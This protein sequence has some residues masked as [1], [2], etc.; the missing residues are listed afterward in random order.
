[1][2]INLVKSENLTQ[3]SKKITVKSASAVKALAAQLKDSALKFYTLYE[4]K[5]TR[6][7]HFSS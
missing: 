2:L 6:L 3:G 4:Q 7:A 5:K 1:V